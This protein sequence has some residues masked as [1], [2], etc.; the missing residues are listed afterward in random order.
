[1]PI[2]DKI[3]MKS[4]IKQRQPTS[5]YSSSIDDRSDITSSKQSRT[6]KVSRDA[7]ILAIEKK[8]LEIVI[9]NSLKKIEELLQNEM[10]LKKTIHELKLQI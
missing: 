6:K 4:K 10:E 5:E 2:D 9:S 8:Q 1:M 7:E 3:G